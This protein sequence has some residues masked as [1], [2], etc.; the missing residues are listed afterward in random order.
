MAITSM[1]VMYTLNQS[2]SSKLPTTAYMKLIDVWL[3]F[4]LLLPFI[5]II[6]LILM[7]HLPDDFVNI[8]VTTAAVVRKVAAEGTLEPAVKTGHHGFS[9]S[10]ITKFA[11]YILPVI[12]IAFVSLYALI[13]LVVYLK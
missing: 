11:Q 8:N 1:L 9:R 4:G 3:L 10:Q 5:I 12:E 2:V 13:A 6:L 7:E